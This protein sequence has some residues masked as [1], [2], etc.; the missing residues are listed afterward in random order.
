VS[1]V[2]E[3]WRLKLTAIGLSILMLGAVAFAQNPPTFKTLTVSNFQ[4]TIP[5]DLIVIN[6]PTKTT[7]RVTGLADT[8]QTVTAD[9]LK[10]TFDLS[11]AKP[12]P[13][14]SVNLVVTSQDN[15]VQIQN[16]SVP[17][18][19]NIDRRATVPLTVKVRPPR[20][21]PGWVVTKAEARCPGSPCVVHFDGPAGWENDA[22]GKANLNAYVDLTAPVAG[23]KFVVGNLPV[24]LEQSAT[25]V[26]P[27]NF[28]KTL[29]QSGLDI[30]G[31]EVQIEARTATTSKQVVLVDSAP[32]HGPPAGYRVNGITID[33][34]AVVV[35]G[36]ADA[37]AKI[38]TLSLP[39]VDLSTH[40]STFTVTLSITYPAGVSGSAQIARVTY[41]ISANPNVQPTPSPT[42]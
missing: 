38:T 15:R 31:V 26:D 24:S 35:S 8:I 14:V 19:L 25:P 40:S 6:A 9:R 4:W 34:I 13:A 37:L 23:D 10:A 20:A 21:A 33:P 1:W 12:G 17:F 41:S 16:S 39:P 30:P 32:S 36:R 11:K 28:S 18:P 7:V 3:N 2:T 42:P 27:S 22:S 29:P 5:P